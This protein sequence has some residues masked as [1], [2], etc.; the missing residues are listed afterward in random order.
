[1]TYTLGQNGV[2]ERRM[3][4]YMERVRATLFDGNLPR[5]SW[6]ECV[7][8]IT[9]LVNMT[10]SSVTN[11]KTPYEL[12]YD[13]KPSVMNLRVFGCKAFVHVPESHRDKL[14]PRATTSVYPTISVVFDYL[15]FPLARL[16]IA[17][18][19]PLTNRIP[20]LGIFANGIW[21]R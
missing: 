2:A 10:P 20:L 11:N 18:M 1:M 5:I 7:R 14:D 21:I 15:M 16:S 3:R 13:K 8:H 19:L 9:D 12:W 4:T 17:V 6:A